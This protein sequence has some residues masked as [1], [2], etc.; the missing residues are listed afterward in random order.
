MIINRPV[1]HSFDIFDFSFFQ[2]LTVNTGKRLRPKYLAVLKQCWTRK[3][4]KNM[5]AHAE[6]CGICANICGIYANICE[7]LHMR[8]N[9]R[10]CNSENAIICEKYVICRFW[11]NMRSHM[12]KFQT[13]MKCQKWKL[14]LG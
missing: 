2:R 7:F 10:I 4:L 3:M 6:I 8:H 1:L 5:I 9:F 12:H 11:Q 13:A 14:M